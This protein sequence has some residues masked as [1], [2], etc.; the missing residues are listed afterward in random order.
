[1]LL[2][3]DTSSSL[4]TAD[5]Q[6]LCARNT[7]LSSCPFFWRHP[8]GCQKSVI[9]LR[10]LLEC[11]GCLVSQRGGG[12]G[13]AETTRCALSELSKVTVSVTNQMFRGVFFFHPDL[14][15][16][17]RLGSFRASKCPA[18]VLTIKMDPHQE[19]REKKGACAFSHVVS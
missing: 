18:Q 2:K 5:F 12:G 6:P 8:L 15:L 19:P 14:T 17:A 1:M 11:R 13:A 4:K 10:H 7:S 3:R 9:L 16:D